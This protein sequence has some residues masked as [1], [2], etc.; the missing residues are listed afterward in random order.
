MVHVRYLCSLISVLLLA[1][2]PG[3]PALTSR[4][5]KEAE[6]QQVANFLDEG[7]EL[8]ASLKAGLKKPGGK[9]VTYKVHIHTYI[10]SII[11]YPYLYIRAIGRA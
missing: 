11:L 3:T 5:M 7:V 2:S 10:H 1:L 4:Q 8:A 9:S 6:M